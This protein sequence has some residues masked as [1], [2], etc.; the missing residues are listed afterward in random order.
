MDKD[1]RISVR[2]FDQNLT[3][4]G[5]I[6][7]YTSLIYTKKWTTYNTFEI[8]TSTFDPVLMKRGHFI[9]LQNDRYRSGIIEY[10]ED[11]EKLKQEVT[12]RGFCP[13]FLIY[14]RP[15]IPQSGQDEETY[16]TEIENILLGMVDKSSVNPERKNRKIP[17]LVLDKSQNR[18]EK[19]SFQTRFK[20][21]GD[22]M[23]TLC[24]T[25]TL[26]TAIYFDHGKKQLLFQILAGDDKTY[27]N[28][29][30][31]PYV[32]AQKWDRVLE[33][34]YTESSVDYKN[35]AYVAGQGEGKDREMVV[36]GDEQ[37]GFNRREI[38]F[39]ARDIGEDAE[40]SLED[41]GKIKLADY[42]LIKSFEA[43]VKAVDYRTQWD[44]GDF[45]TIE[46]DKTGIRENRQVMEVKEVYEEKKYAVEPVMGEA[47]KTLPKKLRRDTNSMP[48]ALSGKT[49]ANGKTPIFR[50]DENGNLYASY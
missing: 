7:D 29:V 28:G 34:D 22:E 30:R 47:L 6:D 21:L 2:F 37:T 16:N 15:T 25:S 41:R 4:I 26:G 9:L 31:P 14:E 36:V 44:L 12:L 11:N 38:Y 8:H 49:G 32:F 27:D 18:G 13:R 43:V 24:K 50:L 42:A 33:R 23:E 45:V 20:V 5:E 3:F 17:C 48:E 39:D 1:R 19:L 35:C 40:M 46:D 10:I